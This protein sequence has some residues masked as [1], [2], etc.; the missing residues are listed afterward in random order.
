MLGRLGE[1]LAD[2]PSGSLDFAPVMKLTSRPGRRLM[3]HVQRALEELDEPDERLRSAAFLGMYEELIVT[4]MLLS[5][6]HSFSDKL[7]RL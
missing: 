1:L 2:A 6:P 5:Q 7:T 4:A 3:R